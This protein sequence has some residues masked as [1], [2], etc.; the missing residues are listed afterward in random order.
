MGGS[1][2]TRTGAAAGEAAGYA[3]S[4]MGGSGGGRGPTADE[5]EAYASKRA[6]KKQADD[7]AYAK[8][9]KDAATPAAR[10]ARKEQIEK[11]GLEAVRPEEMLLP[12]G[13]GL[14]AVASAAKSMANRAPVAA[15]KLREY[16]QPDRKSTRLNSSH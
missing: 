8:A 16:I 5:L 9:E 13:P 2:N 14:K 4:K 1:R 10:A 7:A 11:Q 15:E 6:A 3:A 12:G